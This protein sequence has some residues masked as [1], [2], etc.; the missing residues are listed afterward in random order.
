MIQTVAYLGY[1]K[2]EARRRPEGEAGGGEG[3]AYSFMLPCSGKEEGEILE[4]SVLVH[5]LTILTREFYEVTLN[6]TGKP[7]VNLTHQN[8]KAIVNFVVLI[9]KNP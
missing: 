9:N 7:F 3:Q 4:N 6:N 2:G 1:H 5:Y 8:P